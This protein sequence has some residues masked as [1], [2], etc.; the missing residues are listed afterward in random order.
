MNILMIESNPFWV[1]P[2]G[3]TKHVDELSAQLVQQYSDH[4]TVLAVADFDNTEKTQTLMRNGVTYFLLNRA[5]GMDLL[6][7]FPDP[8]PPMCS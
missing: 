2:N 1:K 3:L 5:L 7:S 8:K 4:I 6:N